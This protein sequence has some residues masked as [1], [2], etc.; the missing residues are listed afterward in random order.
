[1]LSF[2]SQEVHKCFLCLERCLTCVAFSNA[3]YKQLKLTVVSDGAAFTTD[4]RAVLYLQVMHK[5]KNNHSLC[6]FIIALSQTR[7]SELNFW[8]NKA[9]TLKPV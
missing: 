2:V 5:K 3:R 6:D 4:H 7:L 1:M 9:F 8:I